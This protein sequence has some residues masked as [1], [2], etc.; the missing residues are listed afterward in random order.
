MAAQPNQSEPTEIVLVT[1]P[2]GAGRTTAIHALEDLGFETI[3]NLPLSL[4]D[5]LFSGDPPAR[6]IAIGVDPRTRDYS[7]AGVLEALQL[8]SRQPGARAHLVYVDCSVEVLLRRFSETR[9][10]HPSARE[11]NPRLGVERELELL[12]DL[13]QAADILI[14]TSDMSPHDLRADLR[15]W[16]DASASAEFSVSVQSFAFKRGIPRDL[17]MIMDLRFLRNPHWQDSLRSKDGRDAAVGDFIRKDPLCAPFLSKLTDITMTLLPAYKAEGKS[18][19][20]IGLGCTGGQHRSV[21]MAQ[22]FAKGLADS[23][24]QVS[25]RHRELERRGLLTPVNQG[26]V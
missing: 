16:F 8:I 24:W 19:F 22:E 4:F 11:E 3:D 5:R 20:S 7:A 13:R 15:R 25:I 1:G 12:H 14:D 10:R 2:A 9:R 6:P 21:Y 17:E 23:G 26:Q 18:Y